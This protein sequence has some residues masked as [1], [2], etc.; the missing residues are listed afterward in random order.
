MT[1]HIIELT[2][3]SVEDV[4]Q[5]RWINSRWDIANELIQSA[6]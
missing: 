4:K 2:R 5:N 3:V 1:G 6:K